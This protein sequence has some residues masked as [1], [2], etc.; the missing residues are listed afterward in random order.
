MSRGNERQDIV[1]DDRDRAERIRLLACT[2][3]RQG[4]L[5]HAF[6]QMT[7]HDHLFIETPRPNLSEGLHY[8]N[9]CYASYFNRRHDRKGHLFQERPK[10]HLVDEAGYSCRVSRYIHLNPW[11]AGL[12]ARPQDYEWSSYPGYHD[13]RAVLPFVTYSRV[14]AD[15]GA[16]E[17]E[18]RRNYRAFVR[19]GTRQELDAPWV[20][21]G[22]DGIVGSEAFIERIRGVVGHL[23]PDPHLPRM[24]SL[25]FRPAL[26]EVVDAVRRISGGREW[27]VGTRSDGP[28][29]CVAA[30]LAREVFGFAS[31]EVAAALGYRNPSSVSRAVRRARRLP[32]ATRQMIETVRIDLLERLQ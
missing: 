8:L 3:G 13:K 31:T 26:P 27:T 11:R 15:F 2:V 12:A 10:I 23:D 30:Y 4:W 18:A 5:L 22:R 9:S 6:V 7:N 19:N 29:R 24:R 14:L 25:Q 32:R 21:A 20:G 1:R 17:D 16:R 28:G